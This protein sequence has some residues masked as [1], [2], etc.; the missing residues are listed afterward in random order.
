MRNTYFFLKG[1]NNYSLVGV[2]IFKIN[3]FS[4]KQTFHMHITFIKIKNYQKI[5]HLSLKF[6][7]ILFFMKYNYLNKIFP[8]IDLKSYSNVITYNETY[9][10]V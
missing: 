9:E 4:N 7:T 6:K 8:K 10:Y 3:I 5:S 1:C 2:I